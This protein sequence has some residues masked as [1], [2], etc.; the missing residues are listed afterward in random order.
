ML[1]L[2]TYF[3]RIK[4]G[5]RC[6]LQC[7]HCLQKNNNSYE[8][9]PELITY[10]NSNFVTHPSNDKISLNFIGGE[11]LLY[12]NKVKD[13]TK[14]LSCDKFLLSITTN[15]TLLNDEV[16]K[17]CNDNN[18]AITISWDGTNSKKHRG[19]DALK[20]K[21]NV[22]HK[23]NKLRISSCFLN[24]SLLFD[25]VQ[26]LETLSKDRIKKNKSKIEA[27][28]FIIPFDYYF[29]PKTIKQFSWETDYFYSNYYIPLYKDI[30]KFLKDY[31]KHIPKDKDIKNI[32]SE[33]TYDYHIRINGEITNCW[34]S[35]TFGTIFDDTIKE[36]PNNNYEN[37]KT[38]TVSHLC[39]RI[40]N[41]T[42][43]I[44]E[45]CTMCNIWYGRIIQ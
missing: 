11:P 32:F 44:K 8:E 19:F 17:F 18:I 16:I 1:N 23:I 27:I 4:L 14:K 26:V 13:Y 15:G 3:L 12:F 21:W 24:D 20:E 9:Y 25:K 43:Y 30:I 29:Y 35:N 31:N 41:N 38:C 5:E 42:K 45:Y 6:N 22:L 28:Y 7:L 2:S 39:K 36:I 10:L 34:N 33:R 37:C 40:Y